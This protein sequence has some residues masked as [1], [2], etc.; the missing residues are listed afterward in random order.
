M[1]F[2][3]NFIFSL[4]AGGQ[5]LFLQPENY[6]VN[7]G[8]AGTADGFSALGYFLGPTG[9]D[10]RPDVVGRWW[11]YNVNTA[12][13]R[14]R[15]D[16]AAFAFQTETH[17]QV[18]GAG[19][20]HMEFHMPIFQDIS[21]TYHRPF[22]I[23]TGVDTTD[24]HADMEFRHIDVYYPFEGLPFFILNGNAG[25]QISMGRT[26]GVAQDAAVSLY[27]SAG[28]FADIRMHADNMFAITA[29]GGSIYFQN[30][31]WFTLCG[32]SFQANGANE[33]DGSAVCA[34][35]Q[36]TNNTGTNYQ[37]ISVYKYGGSPHLNI[38][39]IDDTY[40]GIGYRFDGGVSYTGIYFHGNGNFGM[41]IP[42]PTAVLDIKAST[43]NYGPLRLRPG[44]LVTTPVR[45]LVEYDTTNLY[46]TRDTVREIVAVVDP[47]AVP[48]SLTAI[49]AFS[50]FYGGNTN[51][52]GDPAAWASFVV[53]PTVY[54]IPLYA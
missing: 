44:T 50:N 26:T 43:G 52:L 31:H 33:F 24:L 41:D 4:S 19:G 29:T 8:T 45:G 10:G 23:Y 36:N 39:M 3:A 37:G 47:Y 22:S 2:G 42:V 21:G 16:D 11:G 40:G 14:I 20:G 7:Y 15:E 51:V 12:G 35:Q 18:F 34:I 1:D 28:G 46:F 32:A 53:G 54:K 9:N 25:S 13:A 38:A 30:S 17:Y 6:G 5:C 27:N 48:P 49:S